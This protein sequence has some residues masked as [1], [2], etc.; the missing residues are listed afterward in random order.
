[1]IKPQL[2]RLFALSLLFVSA[3]T[4]QAVTLTPANHTADICPD[5]LLRLNFDS[6]PTLGT[7]R[8]RIFDASNVLVDVIDLSTNDANN[9]QS[10]LIAGQAYNTYPVIIRGNEAVVYPHLGVL[11]SNTTYYVLMDPGFLKTNGVN[12]GISS[13]NDWRFTTKAIGPDPDTIS[14]IVVAADGSGDFCTVQGAIDWAPASNAVPRTIFIRAG[15]YEEINR[16]PAG[17]NKLTLH[18]ADCQNTIL[19]YRNNAT[20]QPGGSTST[21]IMFYAGGDECIFLNLTFTNSTPQGGSQA[22][23]FRGQGAKNLADHCKFASY[24]DTILVNSPNASTLYANKCLVQGDVD[25]IWGSGVAFFQSCEIRSL[26]RGGTGYNTQARTPANTYGLIFA[27]CTLT[28]SA[29]TVTD[30][31]LGRDAG[32][33]YPH[34]MAAY[35]NCRMDAHISPAGWTIGALTNI[36]L[37]RFWE[38]QSTD[39][40]GTNL[41]NTASR[42]AGSVQ[43]N[44]A[45]NA[46]VRNLTNVFGF[47][48]WIPQ[49]ATYVACQPTNRTASVGQT[50]TIPCTIGG[51]P[52]PVY[53]WYKG[54]DPVP[55]GTNYNL[56]ISNAQLADAGTYSLRA[57]NEFGD[58]VSSNAVLTMIYPPSVVITSPTNNSLL[59]DGV[60]TA[61]AA[62]ATDNGTVTNVA[63]YGGQA[64]PLTKLGE[65]HV[66]PDYSL[67]FAPPVY[68]SN[69]A[70]T[71]RAV[72]TDNDGLTNQ[73]EVT[74]IVYDSSV[75]K[76]KAVADAQLNEVVAGSPVDSSANTDQLNCRYSG[77]YHEV[78]ALRFDL[79]SHVGADFSEVAINL[80]NH[81]LNSPRTLHYYGVNDGTVGLDNNGVTPGYDDNTWNEA[82]G[83]NLK[84]ST[85]PGLSYDGAATRSF[86]V[87]NLTDLGAAVI[88]TNS[89]GAVAVY[90][91]AALEAFIESHPDHLVTIFVECDSTS[92]SQTRLASKEAAALDG[93]TPSGAAG[94]FAPF[95][96]FKVTTPVP[97]TLGYTYT[98]G[99]LEFHWTGNFKLQAQTNHLAAGLGSNWVDV[100]GG[101]TSPVSIG[102]DPA[103]GAVFFRLAPLP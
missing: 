36:S 86:D 38:Y 17:K 58:L 25:F 45:T 32:N 55:G 75:I 73:A 82:D 34:A 66:G 76:L 23:A 33:T 70:Y 18:G 47:Q 44:A 2:P 11:L 49:L 8:L 5:T 59:P 62:T 10:R 12:F 77:T 51:V 103:A 56:V 3:P 13:S 28:R 92:T 31:T 7:G 14:N 30:W 60:A 98:G 101:G 88:S 64:G 93:G 42:V 9:S 57:T 15:Y 22:E 72:A 85:F 90:S 63:F 83:V 1:M 27:D 80:F 48:G 43:V 78:F 81:K 29:P 100:P 95:L 6:P 96:S 102:S 91:S 52:E 21:R 99:T 71:L 4:T 50:V 79:G 84:Y 16:I 67:S 41:T 54:V 19:A 87:A 89:K 37:L 61:I 74:V 65:D 40:T 53:Q 39:L 69:Y 68:G 24:Q 97:P 26:E 46:S 94:D 35:L 20:L